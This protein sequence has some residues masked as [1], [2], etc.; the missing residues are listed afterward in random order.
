LDVIREVF[1]DRLSEVELGVLS[2]ALDGYFLQELGGQF[3]LVGLYLLV[4][5][6][7]LSISSSLLPIQKHLVFDVFDLFIRLFLLDLLV[8]LDL[9]YL[10]LGF[11][12]DHGLEL[13]G[14]SLFLLDVLIFELDIELC[15]FLLDI[16]VVFH[17]RLGDLGLGD[18]DR[19]QFD[20]RGPVFEGFGEGR[21]Q[22][23][24]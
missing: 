11:S 5:S 4:N 15:F 16:L 8:H 6:V 18:S 21:H 12:L 3:G 19:D 9:V 14:L 17:Q 20:T 23:F 1:W 24:I 13:L 22:L 10:S 7:E 2:K